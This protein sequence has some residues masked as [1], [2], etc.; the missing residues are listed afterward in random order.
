MQ[1]S[2]SYIC[3][4]PYNIYQS[5]T[6][7]SQN[8]E[9]SIHMDCMDGHFVPRLGV[10]PEAIDEIDYAQSIDVHAMISC[11]NPAWD[12]ILKTK[13][14]K[15]FAHYESFHSEQQCVDFLSRD[16]RLKLAFKPYHTIAQIETICDRL[17]VSE[18]LLMAYNPGIKVQD[19]FYDLATLADTERHVTVDGGVKLSTV[20]E[21][22]DNPNITL[23]AGSKVLFNNMYEAN[24]ACLTS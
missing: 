5:Y 23:V 13:A 8:Y 18:F 24:L 22:K 14:T 12:A 6:K 10:H 3:D 2:L 19:S 4:R 9:M 17:N 7:L 20:L 11:N 15:I 16:A 21:Q 1:L